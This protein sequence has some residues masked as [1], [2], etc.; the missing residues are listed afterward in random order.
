MVL[1]LFLH[2]MVKIL[3]SRK[4]RPLFLLLLPHQNTV[5]HFLRWNWN[6]NLN[7]T[8]NTF[9]QVPALNSIWKENYRAGKLTWLKT[10]VWE[11]VMWP[12]LGGAQGSA[13]SDSTKTPFRGWWRKRR[14]GQQSHTWQEVAASCLLWSVWT[15]Y[16]TVQTWPPC[17]TGK[18]NMAAFFL[19]QPE[20][21]V[22]E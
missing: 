2:F 20:P 9:Q 6:S 10:S 16:N 19:A 17:S 22:A 14:P 8:C 12:P 13:A 3:W 1:L 15:N 7:I 5:L 18:T 21:R 11:K 4:P